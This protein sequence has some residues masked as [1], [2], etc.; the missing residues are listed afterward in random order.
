MTQGMLACG[1]ARAAQA[2]PSTSVSWPRSSCTQATERV[3]VPRPQLAEHGPRDVIFHLQ[4]E[5]TPQ[6]GWASP[7]GSTAQCLAQFLRPWDLGVQP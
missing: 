4:E 3:A 2:A 1:R 7:K 5:K 6:R